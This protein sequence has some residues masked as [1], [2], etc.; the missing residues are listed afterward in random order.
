MKVDGKDVRPIWLDKDLKT[1]KVIDQRALPHEFVAA[2]LKT[3]KK[4]SLLRMTPQ[5]HICSS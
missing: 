1:V 3:G 2:D 4:I 5:S